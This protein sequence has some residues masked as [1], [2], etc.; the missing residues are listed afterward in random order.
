MNSGLDEYSKILFYYEFD[1][2]I[3]EKEFKIRLEYCKRI[4]SLQ[5]ILNKVIKNIIF[6]SISVIEVGIQ[7]FFTTAASYIFINFIIKY[8]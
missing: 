1:E 4:I 6:V 2:L 7:F 3:K 8:I 5:I